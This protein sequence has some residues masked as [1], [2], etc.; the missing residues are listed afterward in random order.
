MTHSL[1][2]HGFLDGIETYLVGGAVR[3][4]LLNVQFHER[5]YVVV[6]A[7]PEQLL[8]RGFTPVGKDFPVF[9]HPQTHEEYALA[10]TE[11]KTG[12]GYTGFACYAQ[13]DVTLEQDLERRDLT[14]NAIA[15]SKTGKLIDPWGGKRDLEQRVLRHVSPAFAEDPLRVLRAA[16]FA[17]RFHYLGFTIAEETYFLMHQLVRAGEMTALVAERVW[18]ETEKAFG[19][20]TPSEYFLVLHRCGALAQI[21]NCELPEVIH[22]PALEQATAKTTDL[23]LRYAAWVADLAVILGS[24]KAAIS[25]TTEHLRI[26]NSYTDMARLLLLSIDTLS[27]PQINTEV[28]LQFYQNTDAWRRAERFEQLDFLCRALCHAVQIRTA[29]FTLARIDKLFS[30]VK[31]LRAMNVQSFI[32]QGLKGPAI[33]QALKQARTN[34][35]TL[36]WQQPF[37]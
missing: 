15:Q 4:T 2:E 37:I 33:G 6:G 11:R 16:R 19:T 7:T 17:A 18:L 5:D 25:N 12:Q 32:S 20:A 36:R 34:V 31:E 8:A 13:P 27:K 21:L 29:P 30:P 14:I 26:P 1:S 28:A 10:R 23:V 9:L 3:D 22:F 35:L 24:N